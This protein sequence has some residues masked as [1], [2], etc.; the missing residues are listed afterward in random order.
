[1]SSR[2]ALSLAAHKVPE[3]ICIAIPFT[4]IQSLLGPGIWIHGN[5]AASCVKEALLVRL[6]AHHVRRG[7]GSLSPFL[8]PSPGSPKLN[9]SA[10]AFAE[11]FLVDEARPG[12]SCAECVALCPIWE[13]NSYF[14]A[15]AIKPTSKQT[16]FER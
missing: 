8:S 7:T 1:M 4:P 5:F 6:F 16:S 15:M 3:R 9:V 13:A 10:G 2:S 12:G 11:R 14:R